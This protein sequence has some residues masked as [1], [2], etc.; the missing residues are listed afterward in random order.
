MFKEL[1]FPVELMLIPH[2][3][4]S[5]TGKAIPNVKAVVRTD[6]NEVLNIVSGRYPLIPHNDVFGAM[7]E[8]IA[9]AGVV[10]SSRK[11][12]L[13]QRGG[14]ARA[15]WVTE[16]KVAVAENDIIKLTIE[17]R[18]SY[19]YSSLVSLELG[20][21]RLICT[22]GMTVSHHLARAAKRHVP[23]LQVPRLVE[24]IAK[25]LSNVETFSKEW[26][27]WDA[28]EFTT[29]SLAGWLEQPSHKEMLSKKS[30][31]MVI[32]YF[33]AQ[34]DRVAAGL[35]LKASAWEAFNALTWFGTHRV[36]A[37]SE[38][39]QLIAEE[40]IGRLASRFANE[41]RRN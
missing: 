16:Q 31:A 30:R 2:P 40:D 12:R 27:E 35:E 38:Q 37:R 29:E 18:S 32:E 23:S 1:D 14:Y 19:N 22:N 5:G 34:P 17:G 8:A 28:R 41:L 25:M 11:C 21:E 10:V 13:A 39:R 33:V 26:V 7:D 4:D 15:T 3:V 24:E 36:Q 9:K 20:G 6:T